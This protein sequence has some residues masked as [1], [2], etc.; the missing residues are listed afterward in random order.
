MAVGLAV[1]AVNYDPALGLALTGAD[2]AVGCVLITSGAVAWGRRP[3]SRVGPLLK[4]HSSEPPSAVRLARLRPLRASALRA[5]EGAVSVVTGH[6][7]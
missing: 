5:D 4:A 1:E 6:A 7:I 3:E 2:F